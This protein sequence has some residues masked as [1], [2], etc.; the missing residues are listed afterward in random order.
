MSRR[1]RV[2]VADDHAV[3]RAGLRLLINGQADMEVVG[4]A[5]NGLEALA[6]AKETRPDVVL[7]DLTMPR[8]DGIAT[9]GQFVRLQPSPGVVVLTM[10][11]DSA[12][13]NAALQAGARGYV[14]KRAADLELLSAVRAVANG[15]IS[16]TASSSIPSARKGAHA[17]GQGR[18][19]GAGLS[20]REQ[21][22]LRL[23]AQGF[24]NR[25][26]AERLKVGEKSVETYRARVAEKLH[27]RG[28]ANLVRFA[29]QMG[30]LD[31]ATLAG[32]EGV[33]G[34]TPRA[35]KR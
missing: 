14:V 23:L 9:I 25:E 34:E 18:A 28:R 35:R 8:T 16:V 32:E 12:Y 11:D 31:R 26:I 7:F 21:Q 30:F 20:P 15:R 33:R 6:R 10:H 22:V 1:V 17:D 13:L 2:L 27:V 3:L 4:E 24:T 29:L 19:A 5:A